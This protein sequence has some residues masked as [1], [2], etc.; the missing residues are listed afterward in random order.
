[1]FQFTSL[2]VHVYPIGAGGNNIP[3]RNALTLT[4]ASQSSLPSTQPLLQNNANDTRKRKREIKTGISAPS[5][6]E[7]EKKEDEG[8]PISPSECVICKTNPSRCCILKCAHVCVC[9][10][11]AQQLVRDKIP[12]EV[13]CPSCRKVVKKIIRVYFV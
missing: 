3:S 5:F 4:P 7:T 8:E 11:C 2:N 9:V 6:T 12:G 1:M 10:S 13:Q